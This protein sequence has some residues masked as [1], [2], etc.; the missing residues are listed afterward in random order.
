[1]YES[2]A[3]VTE[4]S[5]VSRVSLKIVYKGKENFYTVEYSEKRSIPDVDGVD[6]DAERDILWNDVNNTVDAQAKE[7]QD[8]FKDTR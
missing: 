1:M 4:I 2:K 5:A 6:L 3:K 8:L 7:I